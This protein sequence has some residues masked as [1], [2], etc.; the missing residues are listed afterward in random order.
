MAEWNPANEDVWEFNQKAESLNPV[1]FRTTATDDLNRQET[2]L[3]FELVVYVRSQNKTTEW[4]AGW[5]ETP[6]ATCEKMC[7]K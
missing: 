5:A 3:V 4:T 7:R 6:I 1:Y 2:M